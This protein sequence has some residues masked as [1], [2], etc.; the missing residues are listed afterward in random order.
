MEFADP[1]DYGVYLFL[2]STPDESQH[3][4]VDDSDSPPSESLRSIKE[5]AKSRMREVKERSKEKVNTS[6]KEIKGNK[7]ASKLPRPF[8]GWY[9]L[10]R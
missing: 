4:S 3:L 2:G 8:S 6:Q 9:S 10:Q 5:I 7:N 1:N